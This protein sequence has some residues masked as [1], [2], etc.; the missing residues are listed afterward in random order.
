MV[1]SLSETK[2][3][4]VPADA[5]VTVDVLSIHHCPDRFRESIDQ[6]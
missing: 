6:G 2:L 4:F 3:G 5:A 1:C